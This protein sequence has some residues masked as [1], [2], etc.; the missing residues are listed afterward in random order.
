MQSA[1]RPLCAPAAAGRAPGA[2]AIV[3]STRTSHGLTLAELGKRV[4]YSAAQ[5]SRYER[6]LAPLTDI[7]V[8]RR[9]AAA[10][11]IP[12]QVFG[13]APE[14]LIPQPRHAGPFSVT[15]VP[16]RLPSS[17]VTA[18]SGWEDGDDPVRR[19]QL[20]ASLAVTAAAAP[21]RGGAATPHGEDASGELLIARVR[22]AMLGLMPGPAE[23]STGWLRTG[24]ADALTDFRSC[25]YRR[26][27]AGLPRLICGGH[28]IAGH[29]GDDPEASALLAGIYTLAT[30][31]LI[32]LDDQQLG[33]MAAD[34]AR[35]IAAGSGSP[36][37]AAEASR[38]LAVLARKAGWHAQAMSIALT[39]VGHPGLRGDDQRLAA[40][41]G[42]LLQSAAYTAARSGDRDAMREM[43]GEAAAIAARLNGTVLLRDHGGGFTPATVQ[44]HRISAEYSAGEPGAAIAA[45]RRLPPASLPTTERRARYWTD[46]ARAWGQWDRR[47]ECIRALL[48]A[49]RQAPEEIHARP[50][51]RDLVSGL[52]LSGRT[53]PELRGLARRCG[54]K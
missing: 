40:E 37:I 54:I 48:A 51:I 26:L 32:K 27:A 52:L 29:A 16:S 41:R 10:L 20:L 8:L 23:V 13:L 39:A 22:D 18:E 33:W 2:G 42:L 25:R 38:N 30:R 19:R 53:S 31:M 49:E 15:A 28:A 6:G 7:A 5:V 47:D 36:L 4:G 44:L 3:R 17:T 24:L 34:R 1:R 9:F 14:R 50:A 45:A 43:T 46:L 35:V 12:L 21:V 11:A